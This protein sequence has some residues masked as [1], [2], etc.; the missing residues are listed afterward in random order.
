MGKKEERALQEQLA[1]LQAAIAKLSNPASNP[2]QNF[3]TQQA[4]DGANYFNKGEFSTLPK[5][6]YFD[7]KTPQEDV[8]KYKK[9]TNVNQGGT[10]ALAGNSAGGR[11]AAQ[12]LQ[13]SYLKDR[14]ARDTQQNYQDNI[15]NAAKNVQGGLA[16]A[17]GHQSQN[18]AQVVS[19]LSSMYSSLANQPK[20]P[21][22][23]GSVLGAIGR[24]I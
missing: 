7:F 23:W 17:A 24:I 9:L 10:F 15:S 6:M 18:N 14:F 5:G 22:A 2:A 20:K 3:L 1:Q 4:L 16:Q 19:A 21:S 12:A 13:G 11:G 8:E